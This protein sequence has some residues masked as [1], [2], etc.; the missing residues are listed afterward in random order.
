MRQRFWLIRGY[1]GILTQPG[2]ARP[3]KQDELLELGYAYF[4][5]SVSVE[6]NYLKIHIPERV[7]YA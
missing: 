5:P 6:F 4:T 7:K 3:K 1:Y 2:V